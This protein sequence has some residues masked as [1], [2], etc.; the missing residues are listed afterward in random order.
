MDKFYF[1]ILGDQDNSIGN[2]MEKHLSIFNETT[3]ILQN[4]YLCRKR[5]EETTEP[6][7]TNELR[8]YIAGEKNGYCMVIDIDKGLSCAWSLTKDNS[9]KLIEIV[10]KLKNGWQTKQ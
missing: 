4:V 6:K 7:T 10:E 8:D 2:E 9:D 1:V 3:R 5:S